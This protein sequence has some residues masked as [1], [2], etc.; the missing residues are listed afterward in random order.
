M[1]PLKLPDQGSGATGVPGA[2][3]FEFWLQRHI[4]RLYSAVA[5]EPVPPELM[6]LLAGLEGAQP[7][8]QEQQATDQPRDEDTSASDDGFEQRV[9]VRAYFLWLE[10]SCPE[11]RT[12]EHWM[13]AFTQQAAQEPSG[14][15]AASEEAPSPSFRGRLPSSPISCAE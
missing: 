13:L 1:M 11:G 12:L 14:Q 5:A 4:R 3:H 9:R 15:W 7:M 8:A 2:D 10:D 6:Q